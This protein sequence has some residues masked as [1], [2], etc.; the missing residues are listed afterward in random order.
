MRT[1]IPVQHVRRVLLGR[2]ARKEP[3]S[4]ASA[5]LATPLM[6]ARA[7]RALLIATTMIWTLQPRVR[8]APLARSPRQPP[9]KA[10][11]LAQPTKTPTR[12]HPAIR[13]IQAFSR[14]QVRPHANRAWLAMRIP[15]ATLQRPAIS[16]SQARMRLRRRLVARHAPRGTSIMIPILRRLVTPMTFICA[17]LVPSQQLALQSAPSVLQATQTKTLIRR[18][19]VTSAG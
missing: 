9:A 18:R 13:A 17:Q 14:A 19:L 3:Q 2:T 5:V 1:A 4:A 8:L 6:V 15:T 12:Q 10:V 16:V 11:S 7:L